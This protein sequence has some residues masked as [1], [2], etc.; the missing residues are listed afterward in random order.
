[1]IAATW[2]YQYR[3]IEGKLHKNNVADYMGFISFTGNELCKSAAGILC[4]KGCK[5]PSVDSVFT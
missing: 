4:L 3:N 2:K 5:T 1:L